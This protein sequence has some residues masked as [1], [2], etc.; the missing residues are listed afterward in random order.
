MLSCRIVAG[1]HGDLIMYP[2]YEK[3]QK[4]IDEAKLLTNTSMTM[5]DIYDLTISRNKKNVVCEYLNIKGKVKSYKYKDFDVHTQYI[6]S[7]ISNFLK[8]EGKHRVVIL[9][10]SNNPHWGEVF[11]GILMAGYIPLLLDARNQKD[12]TENLIKQSEAIAIISDDIYEYDI[13]KLSLQDILKGKKKVQYS[14]EWENQ[15]IFCSS[16]TTGDVKLMIY[17]GHNLANQI[18]ASLQMPE[19][20][21]D[22]MYPNNMGKL[23]NLAMI[24]FHHIFGFVAV[25]LWFTFYGKTLVYPASV[26]T[27]DLLGICQKCGVTHVFSVPLLW[28]S[29]AKNVTRQI[30]MME[31]EYQDMFDHIVKVNNG[32]LDEELTFK[33]KIMVGKLQSKLIGKKLR[34]CISGGGY[35]SEDTSRIINGLGYPLY[36][37]YGMTE[38]GVVAVEQCSDVKVRNKCRIGKPLNGVS[39][40]IDDKGELF[41]KSGITHVREI[42]GGVKGDA[43]LDK[44]GFFASG[45]IAVMDEDGRYQ[46]KGRNKDVIINADG[47]NIFP[48]ELELAYKN[49]PHISNLCVLGVKKDKHNE[50]IVL[51]LEIDNSTTDEEF[52]E[53]KKQ[54]LEISQDLPKHAKID[55]IYLAKNKLPMANNMK[56]KRFVVRKAIEEGSAE[57]VSINEKREEKDFSKYDQALVD[58][59]REPLRDAFSRILYLPKFKITDDGHWINDLGGDSMSYVELIQFVDANFDIKIPEEKYGVLTCINDFVEEIIRL[60]L[61][62][63]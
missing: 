2:E 15:V 61:E 14:G 42:I 20:T 41:I 51:V 3:V 9:K 53:V 55:D 62:K 4:F 23:K 8:D 17:E 48:D 19:N 21:K 33:E 52:E 60:K 54:V 24:P 49:V 18:M 28:D 45:D 37:G 31:K 11:Y 40:K 7:A 59:I 36:N 44:E 46:I 27:K 63:K 5:K 13:K 47:E 30:S 32:E 1:K 34:Y 12:G 43:T 10:L 57:Y 56:V 22:L 58:S 16:G 25:F 35:L 29:L 39:F 50:S 26:A 38:V 6:A